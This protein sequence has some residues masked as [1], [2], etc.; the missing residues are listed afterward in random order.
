MNRRFTAATEKYDNREKTVAKN[1]EKLA[2]KL[3]E[4]IHLS[5]SRND[6]VFH[7]HIL[8]TAILS[9]AVFHTAILKT[10]IIYWPLFE[11]LFWR[12]LFCK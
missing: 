9:A 12:P 1:L 8:Y 11:T 6:V 2:H 10:A 3:S 4:S 5:L 7:I